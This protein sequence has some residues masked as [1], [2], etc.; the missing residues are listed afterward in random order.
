[1]LA[2]DRTMQLA[3]LGT[4]E[5]DHVLVE[6][7]LWNFIVSSPSVSRINSPRTC[8][9][10]T[11]FVHRPLFLT[12]DG[13]MRSRKLFFLHESIKSS[14]GERTSARIRCMAILPRWIQLKLRV[15]QPRFLTFRN[16][17]IGMI[18]FLEFF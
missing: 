8:Y 1:M 14:N 11:S 7:P 13:S 2:V 5:C 10:Y 15:D 12:R 9:A 6:E 17:E 3:D 16:Y 18:R 4:I